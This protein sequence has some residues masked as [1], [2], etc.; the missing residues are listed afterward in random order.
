MKELILAIG[1]V[2]VSTAY[3]AGIPT[4][5]SWDWASAGTIVTA[6]MVVIAFVVNSIQNMKIKWQQQ[7]ALATAQAAA[8]AASAAASS[9]GNVAMTAQ[10]SAEALRKDVGIITTQVGG[11]V[12]QLDGKFTAWV[13]KAEAAALARGIKQESDRRD[14]EAA[15]IVTA[16]LTAAAKKATET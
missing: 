15:A 11:M 5:A 8:I 3:A 4:P 13:E 9:A 14:S 16:E 10:V 1:I 2:G 7:A 12:L 6:V